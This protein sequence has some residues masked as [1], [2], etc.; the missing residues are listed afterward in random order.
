M[1][2]KRIAITGIN[3]F[4]G[5]HLTRELVNND[6]DVVGIGRE[7]IVDPEIAELLEGY[8]HQDIAKSWPQLQQPVD[9]VINLAGLA[10]VGPSFKHPQDYININ[11]AIVTNMC[12]YYLGQDEKPRI[13]SVISSAIYS[14][15]QSMPLTEESEIA[16]NSPYAVSKVLNEKQLAYYRGRG[17][18]CIAVRPFNHIGPGQMNGFLIPDLIEKLNSIGESGVIEVGNLKTKRDY[19]DVRDVAKAY[20]LLAMAEKLNHDTYNVC[21]GESHSGEE[22]LAKI[23]EKMGKEHITV[24]VDQTRIRPNDPMDIYGNAEKLAQDT[25]WQPAVSLDQTIE[26]ALAATAGLRTLV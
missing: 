24:Q 13:I 6:I 20:R 18:S 1:S 11:S 7:D 5:K 15:D 4:V 25:G 21:S 12:E 22:I 10:A 16:L 8:I 3:G 19:T 17:L 9:A 23:Q 14:P 26:D 2:E